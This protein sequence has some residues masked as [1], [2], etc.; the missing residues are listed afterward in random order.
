LECLACGSYYYVLNLVIEDGLDISLKYYDRTISL[1]VDKTEIF[2]SAGHALK[3]SGTLALI[4][5]ATNHLECLRSGFDP[6]HPR[7]W[8]LKPFTFSGVPGV[9]DRKFGF[10]LLGTHRCRCLAKTGNQAHLRIRLPIGS[11]TNTVFKNDGFWTVENL[12]GTYLDL[13]PEDRSS[14]GSLEVRDFNSF[15][16]TD[17]IHKPRHLAGRATLVLRLQEAIPGTHNLGLTQL[18]L[19]LGWPSKK[20]PSE[21][22]IINRLA[23]KLPKSL[24][25]HIPKIYFAATFTAQQLSLPWTRFLCRPTL[26]HEPEL[27]SFLVPSYGSLWGLD[28]VEEFKQVWLD[29]VECNFPFFLLF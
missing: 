12:V 13:Q 5:Y 22:A 25:N 16:I 27:R 1:Q 2:R 3:P 24:H 4:L 21:I 26:K 6:R 7:P 18:I 28:S 11:T 15:K 29:C 10:A 9:L 19:K 23:S 20:L 17:I 8:S 14:R